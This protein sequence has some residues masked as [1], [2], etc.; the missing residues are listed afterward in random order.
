MKIASFK[1]FESLYKDLSPIERDIRDI[2]LELV[3]IDKIR[4]IFNDPYRN[5]KFVNIRTSSPNEPIYW[6]DISEYILRVIE[7]LG[8]N[9]T[10]TRVRKHPNFRDD[11]ARN[12]Q[13][14]PDWID[15]EPSENTKIDYGIWSILIKFNDIK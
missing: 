4:V 11:K 7:Y 9:Y 3:D 6:D 8:E 10:N 14:E 5:N 1:K 2:L 15:I 12:I 13:T